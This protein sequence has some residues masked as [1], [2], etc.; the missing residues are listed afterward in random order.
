M[1]WI[2]NTALNKFYPPT[3]REG[4]GELPVPAAHGRVPELAGQPA[5]QQEPQHTEASPGGGHRQARGRGREQPAARRP[6]QP[7]PP[8][9][10]T[11]NNR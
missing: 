3:G 5:G 11:G 2:R 10:R 7:P 8:V 6:R 9:G 4:A 1:S